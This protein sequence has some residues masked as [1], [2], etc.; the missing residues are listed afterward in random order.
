[1]AYFISYQISIVKAL[2]IESPPGA[3]A[4]GPVHNYDPLWYI[5]TKPKKHGHTVELV[6]DGSVTIFNT[7]DQGQYLAYM[8]DEIVPMTQPPR[9]RSE[10]T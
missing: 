8:R 6:R 9:Q 4:Q 7:V 1:M 3:R 10:D 5:L 2:P